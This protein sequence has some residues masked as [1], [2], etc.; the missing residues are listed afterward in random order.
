MKNYLVGFKDLKFLVDTF[1]LYGFDR[2]KGVKWIRDNKKDITFEFIE[3]IRKDPYFF[4]Y[5]ETHKT[6][7]I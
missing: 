7:N 4:F 6:I 3:M 1:E 2:E 5:N